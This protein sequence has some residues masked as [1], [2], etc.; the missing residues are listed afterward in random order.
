LALALILGHRFLS[1]TLTWSLYTQIPPEG[2]S[3]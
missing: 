2:L 1:N 3:H